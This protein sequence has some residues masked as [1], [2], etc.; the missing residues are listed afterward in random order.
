MKI[1]KESVPGVA[2]KTKDLAKSAKKKVAE[3]RAALK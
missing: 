2:G 1:G 3:L